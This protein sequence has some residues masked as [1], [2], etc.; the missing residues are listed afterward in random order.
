MEITDKDRAT[1]MAFAT[2]RI[3]EIAQVL[4]DMRQPDEPAKDARELAEEIESACEWFES[5][6]KHDLTG[7]GKLLATTVRRLAAQ[8]QEESQ[9]KR[10][11]DDMAANEIELAARAE[12]AESEAKTLQEII[13]Q[14]AHAE[15]PAISRAICR[16]WEVQNQN[17]EGPTDL[18]KGK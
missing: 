9:Y 16:A 5:H 3:D 8:G 13:L 14:A 2:M 17:I 1:A 11:F 12:K 4:A 7:Q 18:Y 10:Q 15:T 6:E